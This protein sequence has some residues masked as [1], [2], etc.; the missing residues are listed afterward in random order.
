M[1]IYEQTL[2]HNHKKEVSWFYF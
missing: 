2:Y 1:N